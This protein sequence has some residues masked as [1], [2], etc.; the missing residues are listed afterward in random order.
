MTIKTKKLTSKNVGKKAFQG[1]VKK[2]T[3]KVPASKVSSYK[4]LL[5]AKGVSKSA[6]I[7]T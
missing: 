7:K 2:A 6:K 5:T 1:I 3:I 4:K